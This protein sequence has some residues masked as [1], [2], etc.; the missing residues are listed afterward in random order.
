[1][2]R[3][4]I[5]YI[6][7][8]LS[9]VMASCTKQVEVEIP[10][11]DVSEVPVEFAFAYSKV[12]IRGEENLKD[13]SSIFGM[14]AVDP[15]LGS[16][17]ADDGLN[18]RNQLCRYVAPTDESNSALRFGYKSED[19]TIYFPMSNEN[20]YTFYTYH[21]WTSNII[22]VAAGSVSVS[23]PDDMQ[24][25]SETSSTDTQVCAAINLAN[26]NDV[27]WAK[28]DPGFNAAYIRETGNVPT[29]SFRHPAAG[30][31]FKVVLDDDSQQNISKWDHLT[32]M[33]LTYTG[34]ESGKIASSAALCIIDLEDEANEGKF[35]EPL[36]FKD[37]VLWTNPGA[38]S[39]NLVFDVLADADGDGVTE[40][41]LTEPQLLYSENFIMPMDEPLKVTVSLRKRRITA[42]GSLTGN[43]DMGT[44]TFVLDPKD[45]GA[46]ETGYKAGIMYN[47]K[48]VVK[49]ANGSLSNFNTG[50][51]DV[52]IVPETAPDKVD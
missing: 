38:G 52:A 17:S 16:L 32:L 27:L 26:P 48:I 44:F 9:C 2:R 47:Y 12:A 50:E 40:T 1:M 35:L 8:V 22:D 11:K 49:Y 34:S 24:T 14:Y 6:I 31:S 43:K 20:S 13:N 4:D 7:G 29:F 19:R 10:D 18:M 25:V 21:S 39:G 46:S 41:C 36:S 15:S 51:V 37:N 30:V 42:T 3:F 5:I 45:F 23:E 33:H 28:S